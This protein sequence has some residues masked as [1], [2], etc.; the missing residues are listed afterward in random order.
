MRILSIDY[1]LKKTGIAVTD[2]LKIIVTA[3]ETVP[4]DSLF[5]YL[6][7]YMAVEPVETIVV[8]LPFLLDG[9]PAQMHKP[10]LKVVASLKK[11]FKDLPI[12]TYDETNSSIRAKSIILA[13]G[14]KKKKRRDKTLV[15]KIAAAI[16]LEDYLKEKGIF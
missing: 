13:S 14:A 16:I 3:L 5:E 11:K 12:D 7:Q 8:G 6:E 9:T 1:G 2:P 4:T 10:I 15:D